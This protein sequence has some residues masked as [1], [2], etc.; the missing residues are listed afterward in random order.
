MIYYIITDIIDKIKSFLIK[1]VRYI[2]NLVS[3]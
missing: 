2:V 1:I 3:V